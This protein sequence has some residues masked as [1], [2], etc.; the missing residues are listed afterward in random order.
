M[1]QDGE[2][3]I[4]IGIKVGR[5]IFKMTSLY[6]IASDSVLF[7][8]LYSTPL[9][10]RGAP[11]PDSL[12]VRYPSHQLALQIQ[13][14]IAWLAIYTPEWLQRCRPRAKGLD[15]LEAYTLHSAHGIVRGI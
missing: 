7:P 5:R 4:C 13:C 9:T 6:E 8:R 2:Y 14:I 15:L 10:G 1:V 12:N 3:I 11:E